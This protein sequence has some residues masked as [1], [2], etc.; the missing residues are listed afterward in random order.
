VVKGKWPSRAKAESVM[1]SPGLFIL[2]LGDSLYWI[3][4]LFDIRRL[5]QVCKFKPLQF[6]FPNRC[7]RSQ[8]YPPHPAP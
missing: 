4:A 6:H 1:S 2:P 5:A 3:S 8:A 7:E